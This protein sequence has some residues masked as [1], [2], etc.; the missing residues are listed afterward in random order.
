MS[1]QSRPITDAAPSRAY[2]FYMVALLLLVNTLSYADRHL[3]AIL[4]PAIKAEFHVGDTLL[5]FLGGPAFI[6]SYVL[7][8]L[9]LARLADRWSRR[10]VLALS[11]AFWSIATGLCGMA[12]HIVQLG[13]ARV[14]VG[15]GE[16]G[17]FPPSQAMIADLFSAKRRSTM[18][19]VLSTSTYIGLILGLT[20]GAVIGSMWGWRAAFY[21]L[22]LPGLPLAALVWFTGPKQRRA[23]PEA[24]AAPATSLWATARACWAIPS[25]R[26]L[27]MGMGVFNIFGYALAIWMPT[28]LLRSHGMSVMEAGAW[29]GVGSALGGICGSL[30]GGALVDALRPRDERWQLRVPA[31]GFVLCF[32]LQL[33]VLLMPSGLSLGFGALHMPLVVPIMVLSGFLMSL[34]AG[35][36]YGAVARLVPVNQR[37]QAAAMV[38]VVMNLVGNAGGPVIAGVI[39]DS[40]HA[41]LGDEALRYSLALLSLLMPVGGLLF[42]RASVHYPGREIEHG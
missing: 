12:T 40:L 2:A 4:I 3:F 15:V 8:T 24:P 6:V 5:G 9:P 7:L 39:S 29:L 11:A 28:Y 18:L 33:C 10:G 14:M 35:P 13:M 42:W 22:A 26:L 23:D 37:A 19:G 20:G 21:A 36:S 16:A 32:P 41:R 27:A 34:W 38:L 31:L 25:L 30:A 1:L 17:A